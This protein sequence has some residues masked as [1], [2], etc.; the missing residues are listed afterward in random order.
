METIIGTVQT[1]SKNATGTVTVT[2]RKKTLVINLAGR[3]LFEINANYEVVFAQ[4]NVLT[5]TLL[6]RGQKVV[7]LS[8]SIKSKQVIWG[9]LADRTNA[10]DEL[11]KLPI[12]RLESAFNWEG[13]NLSDSQLTRNY[14][15]CTGHPKNRKVTW[16]VSYD[17]GATWQETDCP[18]EFKRQF[19]R[20][21][22]LLTLR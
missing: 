2:G 1:W 4:N 6:G 21:G 12:Y 20:E 10:E 5:R 13:R 16:R 15:P 19:S 3:R 7:V 9:F 8:D 11:K 18:E 14:N 22:K 17:D